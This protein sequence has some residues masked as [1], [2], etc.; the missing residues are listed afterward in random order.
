MHNAHVVH[1]AQ[2]VGPG[3]TVYVMRRLPK[4]GTVMPPGGG[5]PK[6]QEVKQAPSEPAAKPAGE[7]ST[8]EPP[9]A[10]EPAPQAP[11]SAPQPKGQG[12]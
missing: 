10:A 9:A 12:L 5:A 3:T 6:V 1:L 11:E 2:H 8:T 4:S 7:A